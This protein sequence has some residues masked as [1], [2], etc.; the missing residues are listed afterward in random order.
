[1]AYITFHTWPCSLSASHLEMDCVVTFEHSDPEGKRQTKS[2]SLAINGCASVYLL[3]APLEVWWS[4]FTVD[5]AD[6]TP[7]PTEG[8]GGIT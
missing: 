4:S 1:M 7:P 3:R 6:N 5:E 8:E 2:L